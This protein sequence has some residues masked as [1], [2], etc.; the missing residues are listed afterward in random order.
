VKGF[1]LLIG[2]VFIFA[3]GIASATAGPPLITDDPDTP[4]PDSWEI[5]VATTSEYTQHEWNLE[6]PLLDMNYGIG[7]HIELT[8]ELPWVV[9]VPD[10]GGTSSGLG[11]TLLGVKWRFLDQTN[12]GLDISAYPQIEFNN[13]TS[14]VRRG[15][16]DDGTTVMLPFEAGHKSGSLDLYGDAAYVWNERQA[17]GG[18]CGVAAEYELN[19]KTSVMAELH[20]DFE[21]HFTNNELDFNLGFRRTLTGHVSLIG[22]AG[23]A[24]SGSNESATGFMSY[25]ALEFTF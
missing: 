13:P 23:R 16:A 9:V 15:L 3:L 1:R 21:N 2:T 5:D 8:C 12:A 11:N 7:D 18:F 10:H 20:E 4:G 17:A 24:I 25:L 14:S 19:E 22:S 6:T